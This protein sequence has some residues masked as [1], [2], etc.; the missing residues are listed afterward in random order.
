MNIKLNNW[1]QIILTGNI[2]YPIINVPEIPKKTHL[3]HIS[4]KY[5]IVKNQV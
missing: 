1:K 3:K 4:R 5:Q 2:K